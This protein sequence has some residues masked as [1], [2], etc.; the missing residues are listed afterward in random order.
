MAKKKSTKKKNTKKRDIR[1]SIKGSL[2]DV[3]RDSIAAADK[4][5]KK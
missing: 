2:E 5:L 4:K 3:L 1:L